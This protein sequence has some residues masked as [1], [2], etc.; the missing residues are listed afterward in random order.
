MAIK[1][2]DFIMEVNF[3]TAPVDGVISQ[4]NGSGNY[5]YKGMTLI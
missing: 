3:N 1:I 4:K 2:S 5:L